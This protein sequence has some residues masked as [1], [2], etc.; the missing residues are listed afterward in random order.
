[1]AGSLGWGVIFATV[2]T[3]FL[4]PC[5]LL[6][7]EDFHAWREPEPTPNIAPSFYAD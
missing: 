2:I 7:L 3:R 1:M 5:L 4:L 6:A